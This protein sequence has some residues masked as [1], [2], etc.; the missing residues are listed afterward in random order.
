MRE[1]LSHI[2]SMF[3]IRFGHARGLV[4]QLQNGLPGSIELIRVIRSR[5]FRC[6]W[7]YGFCPVRAAA[8]LHPHFTPSACILSRLLILLA[9]L[10]VMPALSFPHTVLFG[11]VSHQSQPPALKPN[12]R[13]RCP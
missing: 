7:N 12:P 6:K 2:E 13:P 5:I 10:R 11:G 4:Q 3:A 1:L 9:A 8:W